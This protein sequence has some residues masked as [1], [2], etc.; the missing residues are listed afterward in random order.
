MNPGHARVPDS[1]DAIAHRFS[2]QRSLFRNRDIARACGDDGDRANSLLS[3]VSLDSDEPRRLVPFGIRHDVTNFAER[4]FIGA[5]HQHIRRFL[6]ETLDDTDD[7]R[8]SLARAEDDF[9][10]TLPRRASMIY[11]RV[12]HVFVMK[13]VDE[14]R[15]ITRLH[16]AA[17]IS[18]QELFYFSQIH[19]ID[20]NLTC[21]AKP[22]HS[23]I[24]LNSSLNAPALRLG[25]VPRKLRQAVISDG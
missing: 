4:S 19:S 20:L 14:A 23:S 1:F 2:R 10:E 12:A 15:G 24:E 11:T 8:A 18:A 9:R 6:D 13:I 21:P 25:G 7:L 5:R 3:L 17:S 16:L 22:V